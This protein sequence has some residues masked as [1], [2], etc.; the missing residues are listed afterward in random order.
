MHITSLVKDG[1]LKVSNTVP[2]TFF[3]LRSAVSTRAFSI[4]IISLVLVFFSAAAYSF[5]KVVTDPALQLCIENTALK[6]GWQSASDVTGLKCHKKNIRTLDGIDKLVNLTSLSLF[7][8]KIDHVSP[9]QFEGMSNLQ[10][11]NLSRNNLT[12]FSL[13]RMPALS[14]LYVFSAGLK[15]VELTDL[16]ELTLIKF[17]DNKLTSFEYSLLP[18]LEKVYIFDNELEHVNIHDLPSMRY[19]DARQNPMPDKLYDEMDAID[20]ATI[21]HEGNADDW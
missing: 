18:K 13:Q 6:Q 19:M 9:K 7:N 16:P 12:S 4:H 10:S 3:T 5:P 2:H 8:N 17:N 1:S 15:Q 11:L 21:L 20:G 14:K